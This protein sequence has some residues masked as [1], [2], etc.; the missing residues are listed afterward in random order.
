MP[1]TTTAPRTLLLAVAGAALVLTACGDKAGPVAAPPAPSP[2]VTTVAPAPTNPAPSAPAP[3]APKPAGPKSLA[4]APVP[5]AVDS[6]TPTKAVSAFLDALAAKKM[7]TAWSLTDA[8][9]R[10]HWASYEKFAQQ[11]SLVTGLGAYSAIPTARYESKS[12]DAVG[13]VGVWGEITQDGQQKTSVMAFPVRKVT[14]GWR[15]DFVNSAEGF[16]WKT[17]VQP[18]AQVD[19]GDLVLWTPGPAVLQLHAVVDRTVRTVKHSDGPDAETGEA[20][21][22]DYSPGAQ[23]ATVLA[24]LEDGSLRAT[25]TY[26][27]V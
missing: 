6:S 16:T 24:V 5:P 9:S 11:T 13:V 12:F 20:R 4:P 10:K 15:V 21:I 22:G 2:S 19:G 18:F 8:R 26:F 14:G 27:L 3:Q 23:L 25:S 7:Q 17:P 1:A